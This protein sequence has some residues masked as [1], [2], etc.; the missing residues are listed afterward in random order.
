MLNIAQIF[1]NEK[2]LFDAVVALPTTKEFVPVIFKLVGHKK[3]NDI[4][5]EF[6]VKP[7]EVV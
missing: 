2:D 3:F 7:F 6:I 5:S 4:E 1:L